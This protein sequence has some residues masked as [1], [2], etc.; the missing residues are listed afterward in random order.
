MFLNCLSLAYMHCA[1]VSI[2]VL[3]CVSV[4]R[5][6]S[7]TILHAC[8]TPSVLCYRA[9]TAGSYLCACVAFVSDQLLVFFDDHWDVVTEA[10]P[11]LEAEYVVTVRYLA[12]VRV[13]RRAHAD[14]VP[15]PLP[16]PCAS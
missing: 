13:M 1:L 8:L 5:Y 3:M 16:A 14:H 12:L 11:E 2:F 6:P 15:P 10:Y 7:P 4:S 9:V